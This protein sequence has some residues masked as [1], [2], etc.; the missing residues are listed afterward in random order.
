MKGL[1]RGGHA[2]KTFAIGPDGRLYVNVGSGDGASNSC[3]V[4]DRQR[5]SPGVDPCPQLATRA[6]VWSFDAGRLGQTQ[7]DGIHYATGIRNGVAI[8]IQPG[9]GLW[10]AQNGRDQLYDNWP[11]YFTAEQSAES[12]GEELFHVERGDDFGWPYCYYDMER[13]AKVL[14]PEYG[15]DGKKVGRC[16]SKKGNVAAFP[17]HWAPVGIL[18][19]T[20]TQLPARYRD[21]VFLVFHGSWNRAPLPQA[22]FNVVFQPL[23]DGRPSGPYE[24]FVAG[25]LS[26]DHPLTHRPVGLAQAPDGSL[27]L[28][29]D[30]GGRIWKISYRGA[31]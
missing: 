1:P 16:A 17:G 15:G 13:K 5:N 30:M 27:Y 23:R 3:Q 31:R 14:A 6:G 22:G 2:A 8:A 18:F 25:L 7:A 10:V 21:G 11:Q 29:D 19:Y 9:D 28:S 4:H 24:I 20:G 12:P 26:A